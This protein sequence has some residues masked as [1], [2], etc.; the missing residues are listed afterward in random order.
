MNLEHSIMVMPQMKIM[1]T[2]IIKYSISKL[3]HWYTMTLTRTLTLTQ[4]QHQQQILIVFHLHLIQAKMVILYKKLIKIS[5]KKI[6]K[7]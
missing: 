6:L 4:F 1:T 7:I 5:R 2:K 3:S